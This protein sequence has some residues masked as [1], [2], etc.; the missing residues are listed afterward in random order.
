MNVNLN[1][2]VAARRNE[3]YD[4][5]I[6]RT[7]AGS[8]TI[9]GYVQTGEIEHNL[10]FG[11]DAKEYYRYRPGALNSYSS[12]TTPRNFPINIYNPVYG[13]V[14]YPTDRA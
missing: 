8:L 1:T 4:G 11:I 6:H 5:F 7:H 10:L 12:G 14:A 2:G 3:A 13:M 9:N